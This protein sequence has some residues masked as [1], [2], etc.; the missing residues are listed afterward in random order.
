[1]ATYG[2][3]EFDVLLSSDGRIPGLER[4]S[5]VVIEPVPYAQVDHVQFM[6]RGSFR[7]TL[8][9]SVSSDASW[10]SLTAYVGDGM[11]RLLDDPFLI[12]TAYNDLC[13]MSLTGRRLGWA[14]DWEGTIEFVQ[15]ARGAP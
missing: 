1:V 3:A 11:P 10:N 6:G 7:L 15:V 8:D 12:G 9:I 13:V 4:E 5:G 14:E 2:V